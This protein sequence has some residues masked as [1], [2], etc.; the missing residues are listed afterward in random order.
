M[1]KE[2]NK[3]STPELDTNAK[4][5][6][7][8]RRRKGSRESKEE[9]PEKKIKF[10]QEFKDSD[11]NLESRWTYDLN[12][13]KNGPILVENFGPEYDKQKRKKGTVKD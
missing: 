9:H 3:H 6:E 12:K 1:E 10:I 7:L 8:L 13:F 5:E 2:K 11:G 4:I